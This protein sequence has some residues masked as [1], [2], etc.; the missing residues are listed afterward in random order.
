VFILKGFKS[1]ALEVLIL[2]ALRALFLEVR[3]PKELARNPDYAD[4]STVDG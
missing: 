3:I 2:Q 4:S 1:F